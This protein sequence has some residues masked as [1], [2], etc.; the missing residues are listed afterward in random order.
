MLPIQL[1]KTRHIDLFAALHT[2]C[3]RWYGEERATSLKGKFELIGNSRFEIESIGKADSD[4]ARSVLSHHLAILQAVEPI[5]PFGKGIDCVQAFFSWTDSLAPVSMRDADPSIQASLSLERLAVVFNIGATLSALG[6]HA[7]QSTKEGSKEAIRHLCSAAGTFHLLRE[8][9]MPQIEHCI[10]Q[11]DL[12]ADGLSFYETLLLAQ[13]QGSFYGRAAED[14]LQRSLLV[15]LSSEAA[16]VYGTAR[17]L[18]ERLAAQGGEAFWARHCHCRELEFQSVAEYQ[19]ALLAREA[20]EKML[21]GFGEVVARFSQAEKFCTEALVAQNKLQKD[22]PGFPVSMSTVV[23][24]A[25]QMGRDG[26]FNLNALM[27]AINVEVVAARHDNENV[28]YE[29]VP[30]PDELTPLDRVCAVRAAPLTLQDLMSVDHADEVESIRADLKSTLLEEHR[31]TARDQERLQQE[32]TSSDS[33]AEQTG[34]DSNGAHNGVH[35]G[36]KKGMWGLGNLLGNL[37]RARLSFLSP[38][39]STCIAGENGRINAS[40]GPADY[41]QHSSSLPA[42]KSECDASTVDDGNISIADLDANHMPES[43]DLD[44]CRKLPDR[45]QVSS[46]TE[47]SN[48]DTKAVG[49]HIIDDMP[50][51]DLK[52]LKAAARPPTPCMARIPKKES[53]AT[54]PRLP[55]VQKAENFEEETIPLLERLLARGAVPP[56]ITKENFLTPVSEKMSPAPKESHDPMSPPLKRQKLMF[57]D[58]VNLVDSSS[59]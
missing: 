3:V 42:A 1:K 48:C 27:D 50:L 13:A 55:L 37:G 6:C 51:A 54:P 33:L 11:F 41:Q 36:W 45:D 46:P 23:P 39:K 21:Q 24:E 9:L 20:A 44:A 34:H 53:K 49:V 4:T 30:R 40:E 29:A 17:V 47:K 19:G 18:A 2:Y 28:Y 58:V 15:K 52:T 57:E 59:Q 8:Q 26:T 16:Q 10:D 12:N 22:F 5:L 25:G 7:D 38:A 32:C 14:R 43:A 56:S 35:Q 31:L